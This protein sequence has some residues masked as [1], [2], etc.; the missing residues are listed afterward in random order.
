MNH[1]DR[2][3]TGQNHQKFL[4]LVGPLVVISLWHIASAIDVFEPTLISS[5]AK[6]LRTLWGLFSS[7]DIFPHILA[8]FSRMMIGYALASIMGIGIGLF[9]GI[10]KPVYYAFSGVID[11]FRST[12]VTTLYPVFVLLFGIKHIS[13]IAMVFWACFFVIALSAA[14]GVLQ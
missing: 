14:Y 7:G 12:P 11:F 5:P 2:P 10:A 13:K 1:S 6:T 4:A 9:L 3:R 8:T